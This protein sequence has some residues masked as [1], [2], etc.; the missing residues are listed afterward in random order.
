MRQA[1]IRRAEA[2]RFD[3]GP[4]RGLVRAGILALALATAPAGLH[5]SDLTTLHVR[6]SI[7]GAVE[8]SRLY[9]PDA[10]YERPVPLIILLHSW[11]GSYLTAGATA[12]VEDIVAR[13]WAM[14]APNFRGPNN[15]PEAVGSELARQDVYDAIKALG[16]RIDR[17]AIYLAGASGGGHM[18]LMLMGDRPELFAG[19]TVWVP[20]GDL[21]AWYREGENRMRHTRHRDGLRETLGE[22]DEAPALYRERSPVYQLGPGAAGKPIVMY[23]GLRDELVSF[24]QSVRLF[25]RLAEINGAP[26]A[27]VS[28]EELSSLREARATSK[29]ADAPIGYDAE[30]EMP[31]WLKK[32]AGPV[33]LVIFEGGHEKRMEKS[34]D[35][36]QEQLEKRGT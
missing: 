20:I 4:M 27:G 33:R 17:E 5:A 31:V 19:V 16:R 23:G 10:S 11:E 22:P 9:L 3:R 13:G 8:P 36:I 26:E 29:A 32:R 15:R 25:N 12:L 18:A 1:A 30:L 24:E 7:D 2:L 35:W 28:E 34:L 21:A 14:L 6:N